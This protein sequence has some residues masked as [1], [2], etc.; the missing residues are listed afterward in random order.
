[1][2]MDFDIP[3]GESVLY[4]VLSEYT[5]PMDRRN[6]SYALHNHSCRKKSIL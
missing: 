2:D 1:M 3:S 5:V 4:F 6:R